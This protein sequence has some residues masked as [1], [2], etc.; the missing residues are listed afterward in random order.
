MIWLALLNLVPRLFTYWKPRAEGLWERRLWHTQQI[1][2][3]EV[4]RVSN[5]PGTGSEGLRIDYARP[6]PLSD[7]GAVYASS[8]DRD[9]FLA[10]LRRHAPHAEMDC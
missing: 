5:W 8:A 9:G 1:P 4:T 3:E 2:W 7:R 6:A 10:E